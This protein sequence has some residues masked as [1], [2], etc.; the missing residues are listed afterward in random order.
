VR[1]KQQQAGQSS[2][3]YLIV[4]LIT[5]ILLGV[6]GGENGSIITLFLEAIRTGFDKFSSFISLPI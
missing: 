3:E 5:L 1:L 2:Y 6:G 4:C